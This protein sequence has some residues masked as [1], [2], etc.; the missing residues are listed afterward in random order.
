MCPT[1]FLLTKPKIAW[2]ILISGW[3]SINGLTSILI[4]VLRLTSQVFHSKPLPVNCSHQV[5]L[6]SESLYL[7][8]EL[9]EQLAKHTID[10]ESS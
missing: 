6:H 9:G 10:M 7:I 1:T 4:L 8:A 3:I 5:K 2:S